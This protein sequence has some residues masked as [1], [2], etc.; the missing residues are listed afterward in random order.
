MP[1]KKLDNMYYPYKYGRRGQVDGLMSG[2]LVMAHTTPINIQQPVCD[3]ESCTQDY[4]IAQQ[5]SVYL[6]CVRPILSMGGIIYII[7]TGQKKKQLNDD[8]IRWSNSFHKSGR[9]LS[10]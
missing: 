1:A 6:L 10:G 8:M 5:Q 7:A 2:Q 9:W 3:A 4:G